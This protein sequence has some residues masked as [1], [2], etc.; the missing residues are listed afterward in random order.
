M[1]KINQTLLVLS[2]LF[3]A[4][5]CGSSNEKSVEKLEELKKQS[6]DIQ[7]EI[8]ELE[9][10]LIANGLLSEP[11]VN[12]VLVSKID[13]APRNFAHKVEVRGGV[14]SRKNVQVAAETMGKIISVP[15]K[16]GQKVSKGQLLVQLDAE[17]LQNSVSELKTQLELATTIYER[18]AKLWKQNIGT[19]VQYLQAKNNK[20]A[21]EKK[22]TTLKSQLD[23][24]R[25][26]APF[27]G[28]IDNVNAR[29]GEMAQPGMPLLR[30]V[31]QSDVYISAD[32]SESYLGKFQVGQEVEVYFPA[33]DKK[34]KSTISSVG[35]VIKNENRTF[36]VEVGLPSV[37]FPVKPNQVV[38]LDLV[39]YSNEQALVVPTK[40]VQ[41][42]SKGSY[43]YELVAKGDLTVANKVYVQPGVSYDLETEIQ[44]GLKAGQVIAFEGFRELA[45]DV[46]VDIQ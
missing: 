2:T 3:F 33:Q 9:A 46:A 42:D 37:D 20:E 45:Q 36:V 25:V 38:V 17:I 40:I 35:Q 14:A 11:E 41:K 6:K 24:S 30:I 31:N 32:V 29:V 8:K 34:L 28:I 1:R 7:A 15:A 27:D 26:V 10:E 22:L 19:E 21:L 39:D 43:V 12:K 23:Q 5:A 16:E 44:S 4:A 13:L 18:Q